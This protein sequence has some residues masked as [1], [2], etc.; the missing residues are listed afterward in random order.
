MRSSALDRRP[1]LAATLLAGGTLAALTLFWGSENPLARLTGL[2]LGFLVPPVTLCGAL[3]ALGR[4]TWLLRG[5]EFAAR[6]V[7]RLRGGT[8]AARTHRLE[9]AL[10]AIG[11]L[12]TDLGWAMLGLGLLSSVPALLGLWPDHRIASLAPYLGGFDSLG[13]WGAIILAP[14]VAARA[15]ATI[16]PRVGTVVG[17]PWVQF[18]AFGA[19]YVLLSA[20]G[21]LAAAFG[22]DGAWPLLGFGIALALSYSA[23]ALRRAVRARPRQ[24]LLL[25]GAL[26]ASTAAWPIVLWASAI[27]LARAAE[28][29]SGGPGGP[30]AVDPSYLEIIH[31]LPAVQTLALLLLIALIN[32]GRAARPVLARIADDPTGYLAFLA[33]AYALFAGE[34]VLA[35]AYA[36]DFSGVLTALVAAAILAYAASG[37]RKVPGIGFR[38]RYERVAGYGFRTL[39]AL[40]AA[41][42]MALVAGA[43]LFHLPAAAVLLELAD[44]RQ[45]WDDLLPL[46]AGFY[47]ARYPIAGLTFAA[48]AMFF[49]ARDMGGRI[50]GRYRSV[51]SAL[52]LGI[53]GCLIWF[54]ASSLANFGHGFPFF[55]AM[56]A[57]GTFSLA[58]S[59]LASC[60]VAQSHPTAAGLASWIST[61]RVR[62]FTLGSGLACYL[63]MLRPAVYQVVSLAAL[64]EYLALLVLLLAGLMGIVNSLRFAAGMPASSGDWTNWRRHRQAVEDR[65]DPRAVPIESLRRRFLE[66]GDWRPLWVYLA[67]LLYHGGASLGA[68]ASVCRSLR[69]GG[70]TPL[71]WTILGRGRR[72]SART[73]ALEDA[74]ESAG[75]ALADPS[76]R[77]ERLTGP[78]VRK[79]GASFV[80]RGMEPE[81]LAVALVVADCQQ[82]TDV[83]TAVDRWF[84]LLEAPAPTL[85][86][87]LPSRSR[88]AVGLR[89]AA[90]RLRFVEEAIASLFG[91]ESPRSMP[92]S[93]DRIEINAVGGRT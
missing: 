14:Y 13:I 11:R 52:G 41:A 81:P 76:R 68:M 4:L 19:A 83:E 47:E 17:V 39:G 23:S 38:R 2:D 69:R 29:A 27:L 93:R 33:L 60:A 70:V 57:A 51:L 84:S 75:R 61:S 90:Q 56:A 88:A 8:P 65:S 6:A 31:S 67:A 53:M 1:A 22:L 73:A 37:L 82:G 21:A 30:A 92:P 77:L 26:Y 58:V 24:K 44:A 20:D 86:W 72:I 54:T 3:L 28:L 43:A 62:A 36:I 50:A 87:F 7:V 59:R 74:V 35:V 55:G 9:E 78:A 18:S 42:A 79:L 34:G 25:K 85:E 46:A 64:Y 71:A 12:L 15:V 63:L 91:N 40:A 5:T 10:P 49:L 16:R 48:A 45:L 32:C 66:L 89:T 80:D